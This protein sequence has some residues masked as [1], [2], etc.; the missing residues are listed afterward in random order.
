[1]RQRTTW[2]QTPRSASFKRRADDIYTM[3]R[4][5]GNLQ[6]SVDEYSNGD[7]SAWAED[8]NSCSSVD[9]EYEGGVVKRNEVGFPEFREDTW[10]HT[11]TKQ[12]GKGGQY[13]NSRLAA[14]QRKAVACE[15]IARAILRTNNEK[16]IEATATDLM[17][18][19]A[20]ALVATLKR[21]EQ[22]S[23]SSL[24]ENTRY[25]RAL[26]CTKLAA[27]TLGENT[28]ESA[29]ER[30]A[31]LFNSIDD[32]TLRGILK[33]VAYSRVAEDS[34]EKE[35]DKVAEDKKEDDKDE[36]IEEKKAEAKEAKEEDDDEDEDG[37]LTE[38][39]L[40]KIKEMMEEV[41]ETVES[42]EGG[43]IEDLEQLFEGQPEGEEP[44]EEESEEQSSEA[45]AGSV[46]ITFDEGEED[47]A[48]SVSMASGLDGLFDT[49]ENIAQRELLAASKSQ[50]FNQRLASSRG[51]R[52]LGRVQGPRSSSIDEKLESIWERPGQ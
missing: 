40:D 26:A 45:S 23:P 27:I 36:W 28:Q 52:K 18:L 38:S 2:N 34:D 49:E 35:D 22:V 1:M 3:N 8:V 51:A 16:L 25:R 41:V 14:A 7:P 33:T 42:S 29:V 15:R 43:D 39:D 50:N 47:T 44:S 9:K 13:D 10:A 37:V 32:P 12:W 48:G 20:R 24:S 6:P 21:M 31:T 17:N 5:G 19:P 30:L 46:E 4:D 11:G